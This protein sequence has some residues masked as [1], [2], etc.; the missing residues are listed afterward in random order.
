MVRATL[1]FKSNYSLSV[2]SVVRGHH[3]NKETWNPYKVEKLMCNHN[4]R[5]EAKIFE[6]H[7]V[8]TY[9]VIR[10]VDHVAIEKRNNQ[11]F[12]EV[13]DERKLKNG[14]VVLYIYHV[15][16]NKKHIETFLK[17]KNKL[18]IGKRYIW[19]SRYQKFE[20][21]YFC[22]STFLIQFL[23]IY[24]NLYKEETSFV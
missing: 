1:D 21:G 24:V 7:A 11:I 14:L 20:K 5:E 2:E 18:K 19:A 12:S 9:K 15:N 17:E 6:D 8:G 13:N 16:G 22:K 23:Y 10:L 4:K 3:V